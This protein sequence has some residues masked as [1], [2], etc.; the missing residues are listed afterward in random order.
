MSIQEKPAKFR[1][2]LSPFVWDGIARAKNLAPQFGGKDTRKNNDMIYRCLMNA[3]RR[4][5]E[6]GC[7]V[8]RVLVLRGCELG[9]SELTKILA[10]NKHYR[11]KPQAIQAFLQ[12]APNRMP[13]DLRHL[14]SQ[15]EGASG[16]NNAKGHHT[17]VIPDRLITDGS[18]P[19]LV[20]W[21]VEIE[22]YH[23]LRKRQLNFMLGTHSKCLGKTHPR[24][25]IFIGTTNEYLTPE[26][27]VDVF[28]II[29]EIDSLWIE[30]NIEQIWAEVLHDYRQK[31][32]RGTK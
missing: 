30:W 20:C 32:Q 1:E 6:P 24:P 16:G 4:V 3:V 17:Q 15:Y 13:A 19:S 18:Y 11:P 9:K 5:H 29:N 28:E 22:F 2:A 7:P 14:R 31:Q 23:N 27:G 12:L 10:L 26:P 8:D 25:S 21:I